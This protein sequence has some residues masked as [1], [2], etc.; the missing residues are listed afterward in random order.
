MNGFKQLL[1][2]IQAFF[3]DYLAS[4][5]SLSPNTVLAYRDSLK[6]F[7]SFVA[8]QKKKAPAKLILE[9]LQAETVL[10]F[11]DHIEAS[12]NN[13]AV[14]R[15]LRL[16]A[17]RTFFNYLAGEDILR[18]GQYQ[19]IIN[20]PLKRA[21]HQIM[22]YLDLNEIK[23]IQDQIN[24]NTQS[25]RR[26][27][28]LLCLLH[29]TGARVQEI[30]DLKVGAIRFEAPAAVTLTGK[31]R[32]TRQIPLW[33]ET[34]ALLSDYLK[35]R[36]VKLNP[37]TSVFINARGQPL[38]RFGI[39]YILG[40]H[41][42]AVGSACPTVSQKRISPHTWRHSTA[43]HLLQAGVDLTVIQTWLGH[44][45]L[46]TTHGYVEIDMEMKRKALSACMTTA[47]DEKLQSVIKK[48]QDV[49]HWLESLR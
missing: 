26:D 17:L 47:S 2:L 30:I 16:A 20:I 10:A 14:T 49:I 44:V 22:S 1:L 29:N 8:I 43:M 40:R 23:A 18:T 36:C 9:D 25:G 45:N 33:Q 15:N 41:V 19:R 3:Q 39:R 37:E 28:A 31:G 32:K 27:Y 38:T 34:V 7:L 48:N 12:R 5:R 42:K 4:H 21:P 24:R 35:E 6:L 13:S 46:S 11:L